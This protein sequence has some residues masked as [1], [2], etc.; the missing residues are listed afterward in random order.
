MKAM[1]QWQSQVSYLTK[2]RS[3]NS[4]SVHLSFEFLLFMVVLLCF[5]LMEV[6][7]M[8]L[9][10]SSKHYTIKGALIITICH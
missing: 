3:H 6:T 10:H 5:I 9:S 4:A 7:F 8:I 2:P 1:F